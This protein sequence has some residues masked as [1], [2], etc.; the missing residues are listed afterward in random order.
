M[1]TRR[2]ARI[3]LLDQDDR[4]LLIRHRDDGAIVVPGFPVRELFWVPPGG[5]LKEDED[6]VQAARRELLEETG[7]TE[8]E[9][10]PCLWTLDADV[11]W[12][13]EPVHMH[14]RYFLALM[15]GTPA[16]TRAYLEP[17]EQQ[18]IIDHRWWSLA[19]LVAAETTETLRPVGLPELLADVLA[20][21]GV[22]QAGRVP[23]VRRSPRPGLAASRPVSGRAAG[24]R[25][26]ARAATA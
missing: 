6:F 10:G 7:L 26:R 21:G 16:I 18:A 5:G 1:R 25:R 14:E 2:G 11:R 22:R 15:R 3:V 23:F 13:G 9:W 12:S 20:L 19:E 17:G 8:V 24:R 4:I